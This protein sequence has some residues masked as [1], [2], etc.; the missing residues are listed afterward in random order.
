MARYDGPRFNQ[1][2]HAEHDHHRLTIYIDVSQVTG[3]YALMQY[4]E[5][6]ARPDVVTTQ[7]AKVRTEAKETSQEALMRVISQLI[8]LHTNRLLRAYELGCDPF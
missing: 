5:H 7:L 6:Y 2:W 3:T 8:V 4:T 1:G